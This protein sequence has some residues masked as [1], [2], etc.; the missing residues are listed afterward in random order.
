MAAAL[1]PP[2]CRRRPVPA[3]VIAMDDAGLG[4]VELDLHCGGGRVRAL[5]DAPAQVR[6]V[7]AIATPGSRAPSGGRG[8]GRPPRAAW[9]CWRRCGRRRA[10]SGARRRLRRGAGRGRREARRLLVS[11]GRFEGCETPVS[12]CGRAA[13]PRSRLTSRHSLRNTSA[14]RECTAV[15]RKTNLNL[16]VC[17][18][19]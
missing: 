2:P 10:R 11:E 13:A 15:R 4:V 8:L 19:L 3:H 5:V 1:E 18:L 9:S 7:L 16:L 12:R 6:L 17:L 14:M